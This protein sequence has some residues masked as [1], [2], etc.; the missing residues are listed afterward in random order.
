MYGKNKIISG[1]K[2]LISI[3]RKAMNKVTCTLQR[4]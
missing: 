4:L 1:H 2:V 3:H